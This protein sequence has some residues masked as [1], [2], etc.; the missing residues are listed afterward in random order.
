MTLPW[1]QWFSSLYKWM[2]SVEAVFGGMR[3]TTQQVIGALGAGWVPITNYQAEVFLNPQGI[4]SDF[5]SGEFALTEPGNY[6]I[7][8]S[9]DTTFTASA[10]TGRAYNL[11]LYD[12]TNAAAVPDMEEHCFIGQFASQFT[13][14]TTLP[15][16]VTTALVNAQIRVEIGNGDVFAAFN[17]DNGSIAIYRIST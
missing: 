5:A 11:R 4:V 1:R 17:V 2:Q 12:V 9:F 16:T 8:L 3:K 13:P 14:H 15:L 6:L 7:T 10:V